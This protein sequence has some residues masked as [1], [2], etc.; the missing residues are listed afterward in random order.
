MSAFKPPLGIQP[1]K[2]FEKQRLQELKAAINRYFE[3]DLEI[4]IDWLKEYNY[5]IKRQNKET[6]HDKYI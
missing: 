6:N 2:Y 1:R 3:H 5:L 4:N